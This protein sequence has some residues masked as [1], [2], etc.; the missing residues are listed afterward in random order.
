MGTGSGFKRGRA[1]GRWLGNARRG[2]V[3][4]EACGLEV[5]EVRGELTSRA[6]GAAK[7]ARGASK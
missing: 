4:S 5:R 6:R 3:H 7:Q 1:C 2:R